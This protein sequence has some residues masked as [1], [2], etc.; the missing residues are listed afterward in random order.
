MKLHRVLRVLILCQIGFLLAWVVAT[1]QLRSS[2]PPE[3]QRFA[4]AHKMREP[5]LANWLGLGSL[6]LV[7]IGWVGL[8][9]LWWRARA[10]Y[11]AGWLV[12]VASAPFTGAHVH[13]G[14]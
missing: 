4:I 1:L 2:L 8:W 14:P 10:I 5:G 7:V 3:L 11:T 9:R 6:L 13:S 12:G